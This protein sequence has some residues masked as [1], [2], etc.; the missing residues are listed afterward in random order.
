[1]ANLILLDTQSTAKSTVTVDPTC[2]DIRRANFPNRLTFHAPG[3][4]RYKT[5]E[6]D[7][8]NSLEFAS[9]SLTGTSCALNCDH[10]QTGVL[11]GMTDFT[12]FNGSLFDLC[13]GLAQRGAKGVLI[14]GGSD[15]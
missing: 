11:K 3:L 14:S 4:K 2:L 10:C 5:S 9:V 8:H 7:A 15:K 12:A 1:M 6:Y 13:A